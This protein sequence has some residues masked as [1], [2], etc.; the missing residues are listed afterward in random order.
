MKILL[1]DYGFEVTEAV[2][3]LEAVESIKQQFPDLILMDIAMPVTD[4]LTV[5]RTIRKFECGSEIP[6][7]AVTAHGKQ[8]YDMAIEAGCNDVIAKPID[9][10]RFETLLNQYTK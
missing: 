10:N 5:T 8:L 7:I 9:F 1:E 3:G 6:I 4:G 2:D